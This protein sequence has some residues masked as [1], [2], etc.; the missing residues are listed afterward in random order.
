MR[1]HAA[2]LTVAA[3]GDGNLE[4]MRQARI[5]ESVQRVAIPKRVGRVDQPR[6][7]GAVF[8]VFGASQPLR[9]A[10]S[11]CFIRSAFD[12]NPIG[13]GQLVFGCEMRAEAAA[14]G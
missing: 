12:L 13:F 10:L 11:A 6:L 1:C 9:R 2:D 3:F 5:Y 14:V 7:C 8:A 4:A